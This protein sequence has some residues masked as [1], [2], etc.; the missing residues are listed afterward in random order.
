MA[1]FCSAVD[2]ANHPIG[3]ELQQSRLRRRQQSVIEFGGGLRDGN[4]SRF[5]SELGELLDLTGDKSMRG[6]V[7]DNDNRLAWFA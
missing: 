2:R 4:Q 7:E 1:G 5:G 6:E 3:I